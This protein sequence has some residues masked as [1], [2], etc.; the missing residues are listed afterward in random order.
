M[1]ISLSSKYPGYI[2]RNRSENSSIVSLPAP[3][4]WVVQQVNYLSA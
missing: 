4:R 2:L 1:C 3:L